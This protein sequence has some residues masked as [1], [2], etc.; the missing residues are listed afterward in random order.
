MK[1]VF[2]DY[3]FQLEMSMKNNPTAFEK[4]ISID[5]SK[6]EKIYEFFE[7]SNNYNNSALFYEKLDESL[8]LYKFEEGVKSLGKII[9]PEDLRLSYRAIVS[10]LSLYEIPRK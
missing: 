2:D 8:K 1:Q 6:K 4:G 3:F 9:S 5:L 7:E 10:A